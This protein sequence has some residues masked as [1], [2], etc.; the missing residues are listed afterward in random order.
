MRR[1][2]AR[3][4][5]VGLTMVIWA[6]SPGAAAPLQIGVSAGPYGEILEYAG[7][8]AAREG[9]EVKVIE[10]TDW[11]MPN[12]A[13][14]SSD[15][16]ANNFQHQ[17]YLDN[18]IKQHGYDLVVVAKS[19]VVP[20]GLYSSKYAA[21]RDI[22][23]GASIS[24]PNDPTNGARALFL[25][26]RA[27]LVVLRDDP[28]LDATVADIKDNPRGLKLVEL[29]AAQLP[30]SLDDVA[31]S[32]VTL[33]YAVKAGLDPKKALLLED[34]SSQWNLVWVTR[35]DRAGDPRI[36]RL[37]QIYQSPEVVQFID[38]KFQST[39]LPAW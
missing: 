28:P 21:L 14:A 30:R 5:V 22:P 24:V 20:M 1:F 33:N 4:A 3:A 26:Q 19:I 17:P 29:D 10:F 8:L 18:Q 32:V 25:L 34:N 36:A 12:A 13:L 31:A 15:L 9:L 38:E 27:G 11:T 16:D 6:V 37:I 23:K 39:I 35:R 7:T 2:R